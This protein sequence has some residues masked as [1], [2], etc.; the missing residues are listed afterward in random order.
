MT[1]P[2]THKPRNIAV[3]STFS[4][5]RNGSLKMPT[6][7]M[8]PTIMAMPSPIERL[9][10]GV[11]LCGVDM[12][13]TQT[14]FGVSRGVRTSTSAAPLGVPAA[15]ALDGVAVDF[16]AEGAVLVVD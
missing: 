6:P 10:R 7:M 12:M 16:A 13:L 2:I 9:A 5:T 1:P 3:L 4:A 14:V 15:G 11:V 8:S